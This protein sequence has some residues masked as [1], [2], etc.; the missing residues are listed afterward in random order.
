MKMITMNFIIIFLNYLN[1]SFQNVQS[2]LF[3]DD[4]I[5]NIYVYDENMGKYNFL[6]SV[7]NPE[8]CDHVDYV[9]LKVDPGALIKF[10]CRNDATYTYGGGCFLINYQCRCYDFNMFGG[11][12]GY[13]GEKRQYSVNFNGVT[14]SHY[15][16]IRQEQSV[17]TFEYYHLIPLDVN[18]ITCKPKN[19][20]A[21]INTKNSLKFSNFIESSFGVT[22]LKISIY[23]NY[24]IFTLNS[25][26]ISSSR[27]FNILSELEYFSDQSSKIKIQFINYGVELQFTKTCEFYIR[28]CYDSCLDCNDVEPNESSHQ[29]LKCKKDYYFI[30]KTSNCMTKK[31]MENAAYYFDNITNLFKPCYDSCQKCNNIEPNETSQQCFECK[32]DYYFIENTNNCSKIE[33]MKNS[34]YYFDEK[35]SIFKQCVN[36]CSTCDNET[37]C[38]NCKE[39]YHFIYNEIGKC[40]SEP[41]KEDL[42]ILDSK[43]NT[44][45]KCPDG[46]EKVENNKCIQNKKDQDEESS[47]FVIIIIL[48]IVV[49]LII[50]VLFFFIKRC[51]FKKK[52]EN[53]ISN[54]FE[55]NSSDN[56]LLNIF[57]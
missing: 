17:T 36:E 33:D 4:R 24:K 44:Y 51:V 30:D 39:D 8:D 6:Q 12:T 22:N 27:K 38:T 40:I 28:F 5:L 56:Q 18:G 49:L 13:S 55:K 7:R 41:N 14:C 35:S 2:A 26:S 3:C 15:G 32:K 25:Q 20:S 31:E 53:K 47:N 19:I 54:T 42:L 9:D 1:F 45:I 43:T 23:S 16:S 52:L 50:I 11:Y 21:P 37:Y 34:S 48:I 29:C 57:I 46:T 10:E